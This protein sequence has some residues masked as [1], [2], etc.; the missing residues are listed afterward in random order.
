MNIDLDIKNIDFKDSS[1]KTGMFTGEAVENSE[2]IFITFQFPDNKIKTI[3]SDS[4]SFLDNTKEIRLPNSIITIKENAF[5][6]SQSIEKL[7]LG[8]SLQEIGD[9]AFMYVH[10]L[11]EVIIPDSVKSIG[12]GGIQ[13]TKNRN[14]KIIFFISINRRLRF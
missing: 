12:M 2:N 1:V 10:N 11:K 13:R 8:N 6:N 3:E 14:I 7:T 5:Q 4:F 9:F